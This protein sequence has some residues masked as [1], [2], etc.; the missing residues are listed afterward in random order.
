MLTHAI[1]LEIR[2]TFNSLL[3][4]N[5][6]IF[7]QSAFV[8]IINE[9]RMTMALLFVLL[10]KLTLKVLINCSMKTSTMHP[11]FFCNLQVWIKS[12]LLDKIFHNNDTYVSY[13]ES[14][15]WHYSEYLMKW[16]NKCR[17]VLY[18]LINTASLS[19][20]TN[21]VNLSRIKII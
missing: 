21:H 4:M 16:T 11:K 5:S 1:Q 9:R 20:D 17:C 12:I 19:C 3:R 10:R 14:C 13:W 15:T 8:Q 2:M 6:T 7:N 18:P